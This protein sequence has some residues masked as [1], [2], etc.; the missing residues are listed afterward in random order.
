MYFVDAS[1]IVA[2]LKPEADAET[3]VSRLEQLGGPFLVSPLVRMEAMLAVTNQ[4][5]GNATVEAF[6]SRDHG[7]CLDRRR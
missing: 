1:V 3:W 7:C 6:A 5:R 4:G 2:V